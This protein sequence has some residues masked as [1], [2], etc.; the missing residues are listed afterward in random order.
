MRTFQLA[1]NFVWFL[2]FFP[3]VKSGIPQGNSLRPITPLKPIS[4]PPLKNSYKDSL[5]EGLCGAIAGTAQVACLMWL[6]TTM[7]YQ[8]RYGLTLREALRELYL[9][10]LSVN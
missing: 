3:P 10:G 4:K 8:H 9:Q 6:R 2:V 7:S 5:R 1:L